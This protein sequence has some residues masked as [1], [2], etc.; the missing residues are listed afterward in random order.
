MWERRPGDADFGHVRVGMG[1]QRL[2]T[3]WSRPNSSPAEDLDPVTS[4]ELRRL[5]R[6][7]ATVPDLPV[8]LALKEI[9]CDHHER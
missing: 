2:S 3:P 6:R 9:A 7:R 8:S 4:M 5:F 1:T